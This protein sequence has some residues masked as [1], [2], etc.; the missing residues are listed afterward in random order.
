MISSAL[1]SD[2]L[3]PFL[4]SALADD[5]AF[6]GEIA[7]ILRGYASWRD[8]FGD[9]SRRMEDQLF[10]SLYERLGPGMV[11]R[12][13]EGGYRR[14]LMSE[15]PALAEEALFPLF[16]SL[17]PYSVNYERLRSFWMESGSFSAMRALYF[18]F[19]DFLLPQEREA[20]ERIARENLPPERLKVWLTP[21]RMQ[22]A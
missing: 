18:H 22:D 19:S 4:G 12:T 21:P 16:A 15:L 6:V 13:P 10:N 7:G 3:R 2:S 1:I 11:V 20:M 14:I 9:L 8:Q 5:P 17:Q